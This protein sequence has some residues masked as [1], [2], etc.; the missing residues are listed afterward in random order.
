MLQR[1]VKFAHVSSVNLA[2]L[3]AL[4][5]DPFSDTAVL[6][7]LLEP[8]PL[9]LGEAG[10]A[11]PWASL[12]EA[13]DVVVVH[14]VVNVPTGAPSC[15]SRVSVACVTVARLWWI[16]RRQPTVALSLAR[17]L[18]DLPLL[19]GVQVLLNLGRKHIANGYLDCREICIL[20]PR[21][22]FGRQSRLAVSKVLELE[23]GRDFARRPLAGPDSCRSE[24]SCEAA[25]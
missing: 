22:P 7:R 24:H 20:S 14:F 23:P 13:T 10:A 18:C 4:G 6:A 15:R 25:C 19:L 3:A 5:D 17:S 11:A 1:F 21:K 9:A 16:E 2:I 12:G 8:V